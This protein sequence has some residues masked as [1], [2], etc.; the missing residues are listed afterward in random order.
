M[1]LFGPFKNNSV[2]DDGDEV[3]GDGGVDNNQRVALTYNGFE[4]ISALT[5]N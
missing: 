2:V 3:S 4:H 1:F 5:S